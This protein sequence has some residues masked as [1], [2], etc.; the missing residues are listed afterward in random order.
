MIPENYKG[1]EQAYIKHTLLRNYLEKLFMIVGQHQKVICYIDCFAGPWQEDSDTL[2]D[3]SISIS[4]N[5]INK[6]QTALSRL[7]KHVHF[8][9][10]FIEKNKK[11]FSK[12]GEFLENKKH[13]NIEI[14]KMHGDFFDLRDSICSWCYDN[15]FAFFF[16]DPTGWRKVIEIDTLHPLLNRKNSEY[17]I[18]FMFDYILRTHTQSG[19]NKQMKEIFGEVPNT[20]NLSSD[21]RENNEITIPYSIYP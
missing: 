6:C 1:R 19:F 3:T 12:L 4:L 13:S 21:E 2:D 17:L 8:R 7:G 14:N 20:K 15:S 5:I 10:L 16:I 11:S 18:N 9:A